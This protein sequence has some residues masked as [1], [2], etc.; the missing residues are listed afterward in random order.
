M[1]AAAEAM[2][3]CRKRGVDLVLENGEVGL[4][5]PRAAVDEVMPCVQEHITE[6]KRLVT[7]LALAIPPR[8]AER[9]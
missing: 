3:T 2:I 7:D 9:N 1:S 5:G 4:V 6:V 8:A